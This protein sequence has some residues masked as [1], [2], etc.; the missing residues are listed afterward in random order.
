MFVCCTQLECKSYKGS[1]S[2]LSCLPLTHQ[3]WIESSAWCMPSFFVEHSISGFNFIQLIIC[4]YSQILALHCVQDNCLVFASRYTISISEI[5]LIPFDANI[6]PF[7]LGL[8][9]FWWNHLALTDLFLLSISL[10]LKY[11]PQNSNSYICNI[12]YNT[13]QYSN[14]LIW[15]A[16]ISSTKLWIHMFV[17]IFTYS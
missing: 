15:I 3:N 16:I 14:F 6:Q 10:S 2:H 11:S 1:I 8:P 13:I 17:Y 7:Q 4:L 9:K 12:I 5:S